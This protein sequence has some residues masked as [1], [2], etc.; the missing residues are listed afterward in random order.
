MSGKVVLAENPLNYGNRV[1]LDIQ[2]L[3]AGIYF[4]QLITNDKV[5]VK[6]FSVVK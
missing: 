4:L 2:K 3:D 6:R 5:A 1:Q